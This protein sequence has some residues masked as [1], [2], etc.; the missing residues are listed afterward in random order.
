MK[1]FN[2]T[3]E[4]KTVE[5]LLSLDER[6]IKIY[7]LAIDYTVNRIEESKDFY[8]DNLKFLIIQNGIGKIIRENSAIKLNLIVS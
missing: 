1:K 3:D 6:D 2:K 4:I 7:Y 8:S 5:Q